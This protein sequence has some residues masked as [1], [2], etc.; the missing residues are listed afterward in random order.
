MSEWYTRTTEGG[1]ISANE[2]Q[3][4]AVQSQKASAALRTR[5]VALALPSATTCA[6]FGSTGFVLW[7]PSVPVSVTSAYLVPLT[8]WCSSSTAQVA[9]DLWA[10]AAG[11]LGTVNTSST[12]SVAGGWMP[13]TLN[14]TAATLSA[15]ESLMAWGN[16]S[17][18]QFAPPAFSIIVNYETTG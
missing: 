6:G 14:S 16:A 4:C 11:V 17:S 18:C 12:V 10:C 8:P 15:N 9:V 2:V 1:F 13:I 3:S 5:S 7:R